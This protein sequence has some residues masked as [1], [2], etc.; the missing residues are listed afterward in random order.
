MSDDL[1]LL[2]VHAEKK[3][4]RETIGRLHLP[5]SD[6]SNV[7]HPPKQLQTKQDT[8]LFVQ[9]AIDYL[10]AIRYGKNKWLVGKYKTKKS[11]AVPH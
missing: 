8:L 11:I 2:F 6:P 1:L 10:E 3:E 4:Q 5:M 7:H 9:L